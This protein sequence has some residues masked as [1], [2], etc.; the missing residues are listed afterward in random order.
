FVM[1][2]YGIGVGRA[3]QTIIETCRDERGIV[4]P[5]A[6]APFE[7]HVVALPMSDAAVRE[8]AESLVATLEHEG[9]QVLF[10]DREE[11]AGVKFADADLIGIPVRVTVSKRGLAA[12]TIEWKLRSESEARHI[13]RDGAARELG[14][15]V[16]RMREA[17]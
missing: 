6:V 12:G 16:R 17:R 1:G 11:S 5:F 15:T 9:V 2:S 3:V 7:V 10:D 4:W 14:D 8:T 13:P